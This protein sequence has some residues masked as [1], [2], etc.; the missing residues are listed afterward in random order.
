M[1][2]TMDFGE[3]RFEFLE[4]NDAEVLTCYHLVRLA[5]PL[6]LLRRASLVDAPC[7]HISIPRGSPQGLHGSFLD[8]LPDAIL[9]AVI[10]QH[11]AFP[12]GYLPLIHGMAAIRRLDVGGS[13]DFET[14]PPGAIMN[15]ML[16]PPNQ[17]IRMGLLLAAA[18]AVDDRSFSSASVA[19]TEIADRDSEH[20]AGAYL[21][22]PVGGS[23]TSFTPDSP[24]LSWPQI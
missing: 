9:I 16:M 2:S 3:V 11:A 14:F 19:G 6:V 10:Y 15:G 7:L 5:V 21:A 22:S 8:P 1:L 20:S 24:S 4:R 18:D 13:L 23:P 12:A 17:V